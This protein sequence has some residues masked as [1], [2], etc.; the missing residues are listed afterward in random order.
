MIV[1]NNDE[2]I[3][4]KIYVYD[5]DNDNRYYILFPSLFYLSYIQCCC[6]IIIVII[7]IIIIIT[8]ITIITI[9]TIT[10]TTTTTTITI[11]ICFTN[12]THYDNMSNQK[13]NKK[14]IVLKFT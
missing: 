10:I 1:K 5:V 9:T 12:K 11:T 4:K 13:N 7:I 3:K 14:K 2:Y 6:S 8:I